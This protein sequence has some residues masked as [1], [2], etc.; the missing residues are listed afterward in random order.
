MTSSSERRGFPNVPSPYGE[1]G[2]S[3]YTRFIPREELKEFSSWTPSSFGGEVRPAPKAEAPAEPTADQ[4][5]QQVATARQA[6]YQ[7]GYRDGLAALE[8]FKQGFA[9]QTTAQV[10]KLL[11]AFD[12]QLSALEQDMAATV[13]RTAALLARQVLRQEMAAQ[14]TAAG[15]PSPSGH[16]SYIAA[17]A[18]E[19][20]NAV[21]MSARQMVVRV[22]PDDLPLVAQGAAET[23]AARGARLVAD[24]S[25]SRGGVMIDSDVGTLDASLESRWAQAAASV[26]SGLPLHPAD[27]D[28]DSGQ[29]AAR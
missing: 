26:G 22:H 1:K 10:G 20:V 14:S 28:T 13:A 12:E 11:A 23:L 5:R 18:Q 9:A 16:A 8:G 25:V 24:T 17:L 3:P 21:L 6:G 2:P 15:S 4:W 27:T 19:A 7:E 29:G